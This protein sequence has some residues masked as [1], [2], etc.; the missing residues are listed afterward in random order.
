MKSG[1]L[2]A[3]VSLNPLIRFLP[4]NA[5]MNAILK[6]TPG[7]FTRFGSEVTTLTVGGS[8]LEGEL[9]T[10]EQFAQN[11]LVVLGLKV[12]LGS[13]KKI[14]RGAKNTGNFGIFRELKAFTKEDLQRIEKAP[15]EK[16]DSIISDIASRQA[17]ADVKIEHRQKAQKVVADN[18]LYTKPKATSITE[19][20]SKGK[21]VQTIPLRQ[22][23]SKAIK[24]L[25]AKRKTPERTPSLQES[26]EVVDSR[27]ERQSDKSLPERVVENVSKDVS[28][29]KLQTS[30]L[31]DL[32]PVKDFTAKMFGVT[33]LEVEVGNV[34]LNVYMSLRAA[35]GASR[36]A[37]W[38]IEEHQFSIKDNSKVL[39][40]GFEKILERF[41]SIE[42]VNELMTYKVSKRSVE[43][44]KQGFNTGIPLP[45]SKVIA[46][47]LSSKYEKASRELAKFSDNNLTILREAGLTN[48]K[49][50]SDV[51]A[52]N[53]EYVSYARVFADEVQK[54]AMG[55]K[56]S[57]ALK[58]FKGVDPNK[59]V[60]KILDPVESYIADTYRVMD[61]VTQ[62]MAG[63]ELVKASRLNPMGRRMIQ[64]VPRSLQVTKASKKEIID[65]LK[66]NA[67]DNG[68]KLDPSVL[69]LM[70]K[71]SPE[72]FDTVSYTHLTLP[73]IL[74]V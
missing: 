28:I 67:K 21:A 39:G 13:A 41:K 36:M 24:D 7:K 63:Q 34:P 66:K 37:K 10:P 40:P 20:R 65:K 46:K 68:E 31:N 61:L 32:Y 1:G 56:V 72:T 55:R 4:K 53:K 16:V 70:E 74:L 11:A 51:R 9:P 19:L 14:I 59:E 57:K 33:P 3:I 69:N 27:I 62:N 49:T 17:K 23:K 58:R 52:A 29:T 25:S 26:L 71:A 47:E 2:G 73:T 5:A 60:P 22:A 43:K 48:K 38:A 30:A 18:L 44:S 45:E 42:E 12:S 35:K 8:A 64:E 50:E 15:I 54:S 6:G